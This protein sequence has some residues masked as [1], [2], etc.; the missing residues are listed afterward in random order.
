MYTFDSK[1]PEGNIKL[2]IDRLQRLARD[3]ERARQG[4]HPSQRE[5]DRAPLL[6][7]WQYAYRAEI[8]LV[9]TVSGHP[10]ITDNHLNKTS[11]LWLLSRDRGYARTHSR[12]YVLGRPA[13]APYFRN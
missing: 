11:G 12:F 8:C 10:E 13:A 7:N 1:P 2:A 6:E 5:L 4:H 3:L 9:G